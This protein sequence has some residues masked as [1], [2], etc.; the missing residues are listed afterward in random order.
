MQHARSYAR[1][2]TGPAP[3]NGGAARCKTVPP[4]ATEAPH[5]AKRFR[6]MQRKLRTMRNWFRRMQRTFRTTRT[7]SRRMQRELRT[8]ANW[9]RRVQRRFRTMQNWFRRM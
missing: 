7:W 5:N 9:S 8:D 1:R 2:E 6:R 4:R 3:C